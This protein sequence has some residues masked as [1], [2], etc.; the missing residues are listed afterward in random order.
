[1]NR[2]HGFA[3]FVMVIETGSFSAAARRMGK[4]KAY[5]SQKVSQLEERLGV[6]LLMR[7]TRKLALTEAGEIYCRYAGQAIDRLVEGEERARDLQQELKGK[8]RVSIVDGGLGE[9]FLAPVLARFAA[10]N[11]EV[12]VEL[13]LSSR[14]VDLVGEGFDFAIRVGNLKDSSLVTRKLTS[15][16]FGLYA[17]PTYIERRGVVSVPAQ[18]RDHNCLTGATAR[19]VFSRNGQNH[20]IAP[21]GTWH[22][23]SG[24]ALIAAASEG[25]GIART[26]SF[27]AEEALSQGTVME[28]LPDWTREMTPVWI[29][30]PGAGTLP[31]RVSS[32]INF[33]ID[34]FREHSF[35]R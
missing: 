30:R 4:S 26:A 18:L 25:L 13:D 17:S 32:A 11:P 12:S 35:W 21:A 6:R 14:L 9:W 27:Y 34:T 15:F 8:I 24:Q 10:S 28:V 3:E 7:T 1:M 19:W 5:V 16:R 33:L 31:R 20:E 23:K 29:V 22:S 2:F